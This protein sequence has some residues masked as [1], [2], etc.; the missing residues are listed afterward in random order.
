MLMSNVLA[1]LDMIVEESWNPDR[2]GALD[3]A[4]S[5]VD[6]DKWRTEMSMCPICS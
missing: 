1:K 6:K 3:T 5:K 4:F 2:L